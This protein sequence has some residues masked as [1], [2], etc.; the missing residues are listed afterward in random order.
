MDLFA[1]IQVAD[2]TKVKVGERERAEEE[3][4]LLDST[5]GCVISLLPVA[6]ARS[7]NKLQASVERLFDESGSADQDNV[8]AKRPKHPQ[9]KRQAATDASGSSHDPKKL[10][11][12]YGAS[13]EAAV[14]GKSPSSLKELLASSLLNVEVGVAALPTLPMVTSSVSATPEHESGALIDSITG[15]N[16]HT[17]GGSKRFII[18][19][20]SSCHSST[21]ASKAE[22]DSIIRSVVIPPVITEVVV[23][24][25]VVNI[26]SVLEMG[27]RVT[28]HVRAS[29][30][31]DSDYTE[32]VK[33]DAKQTMFSLN[34]NSGSS[35]ECLHGY[36]GMTDALSRSRLPDMLRTCLDPILSLR[37]FLLLG[38][39]D[40]EYCEASSKLRRAFKAL[41][42]SCLPKSCETCS[43]LSVFLTADVGWLKSCTNP[44]NET[45]SCKNKRKPLALPW[46]RT[47]RLS[48]GVSRPPLQ[49]SQILGF[50]SI[51]FM[52]VSGQSGTLVGQ[53]SACN[54]G[55]GHR[56]SSEFVLRKC[57]ICV[58]LET[59]GLQPAYL[60]T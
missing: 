5:I 52:I 8:V 48:S 37:L 55:C 41:S 47:L 46:G 54:R 26:P 56:L 11:V 16:I 24:S 19:S 59:S 36:C 45:I 44:S 50:P 51:P 17:I 13:S 30:F 31:Q 20:D 32:A 29:L 27:V 2:P 40:S 21:H 4:K 14:C 7:K 10:K 9:K 49:V 22:G 18:S 34:E 6:P 38:V 53:E 35:F 23:T 3:A 58:R 12:D 25:H 15:L 39:P 57:L 42:F 1:F 33:A 60:W 28:S 43:F